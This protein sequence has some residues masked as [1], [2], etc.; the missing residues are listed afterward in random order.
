MT[1]LIGAAALAA[2]ALISR[3]IANP[4]RSGGSPYSTGNVAACLLIAAV[5]IAAVAAVAARGG[6]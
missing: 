1:L 5:A 2:M 4:A 3:A 6:A